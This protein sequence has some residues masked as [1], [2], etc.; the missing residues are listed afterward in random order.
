MKLIEF[1]DGFAVPR[2]KINAFLHAG[3]RAAR[4]FCARAALTALAVLWFAGAAPRAR[5]GEAPA[6][7]PRQVQ[8]GQVVELTFTSV[9]NYSDPFNAVE[10][11]ALVTE[12]GGRLLRVPAFWAGGAQWRVR[13]ASDKIGRHTYRTE[14]SDPGNR[15]LQGVSGAVEVAPY[16]GQN[17]LYQHG[18]LR[19]APSR[20]YLEHAD[21]TPFFWLGD[22]WWMGLSHRLHWPGEF[23]QLAADR[24]AKGFNVIQIVAGLYPDMPAFDPRGANEAGFPWETNYA[25]MRPEYFDAAD[26]RLGYLVEEGFVP[27]I[28]GAWGYFLPW[29][30]VDKAKRHWRYLI[31]R[32]GAWPVVWCVA[33]EANLPW[34]LAPGFPYDDRRQVRGWTEVMRYVREI[35]PFHRLVT[36]HPTAIGQYTARHAT[37][38]SVLLDFDMLQTPHGQREAVPITV[39]AVRD[40]YRALPT[41]PVINGEASYEMLSDSLPTEWTRR[42]FWLCLMN[43]A[44]GHTYGANGIWQVNRKDQP[45]GASPHGGNYG[46]ITWD[47]AMRLPG[48]RQVGLGK[49]LFEQYP[50]PQFKPHP[51]WAEFSAGA[52]LGFE[53]CHWLWYPEGEPAR[54]APTEKRFFQKTFVLPPGKAVT[55]ARLRVSADDWFA[56]RL[57][58]QALGQALDAVDSWHTGRQFEGLAPRLK[59]GTNV[60]AIIAENRPSNVPANPAGMIARLEVSFSDGES[61]TLK[62]DATWRCA[63]AESAG[64]DAPGFD[65]STWVP[66]KVLGR[67]GDSPWGSLTGAKDEV[68]GPQAAGIPGLVRVIYVPGPQPIAVRNL[69][70]RASYRAAYFDPVS[71]E[72]TPLGEIRAGEDGRWICPAPAG[73]DHDWVLLLETRPSEGRTSGLPAKASSGPLASTAVALASE[74]AA[75]HLDW[76][77]GRLRS[78]AFENKISHRRYAISDSREVAL[79][80]SAALDR[81]AE[82]VAHVADFTVREARLAG[83]AHAVFTLRSPLA[84]LEVALNYQLDGPTRRKWLEVTNHTG[85]E[86]LLLDV[87]LDDFTAEGTTTGGGQGQPVFIEDECFAAV[88][89]PSGINQAN[90]GRVQLLHH[91][92]RRLGVGGAFRSFT[93]AVSMAGPGRAAE[94]FVD[95]IDARSRRQKKVL[96]IYT[97]FGINNQWGA[98]PTLDDEQALNVLGRLER[99]QAQGMRLDY[100]TLDTGW[101][102][103][104]SDLTRFRTT[105]YPNGPGAL[106]ERVQGLGMNFGLW[107]A[108][109][110][111]AES[112]WDNPVALAGQGTLSR[113]IAWAT[114]TGRAKGASSASPSSL[115]FARSATR[116]SITCAITGCGL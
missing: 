12:P 42:M 56:A 34:Y 74:Q 24:K 88:E 57:N 71:G 20:R 53:G 16:R 106:L 108:T 115:I 72:K 62:T 59:A 33:G 68:Q 31:A 29:M 86:L 66:A 75:W 69:G 47:E 80:F 94:G 6:S 97:P 109:S 38:E 79:H 100:F 76:A 51:E 26:Q 10:L 83:P 60:L 3:A 17:P 55:R 82:P 37:D 63:K 43:G 18:P 8:A 11:D 2:P 90:R 78:T 21:G 7:G 49:R 58:G 9:T 41:L 32:Y 116:S 73:Q 48:S 5:A 111:A 46:K 92:G 15:G 50:W 93:A 104:A 27:C 61:L 23:Q 91:P 54:D 35:D 70:S 36:I 13:Y 45:H 105:C 30:G 114:P 98:C 99:W 25:R 95:Y 44:A 89:H 112:C 101:V 52:E 65:S 107:F 87:E 85:K 96:S 81:V 77:D 113:L 67:H 84:G 64:W 1:S 40:S 28:V 4:S 102:D 39:K 19:V 22:T 14:C 103:P 110:W